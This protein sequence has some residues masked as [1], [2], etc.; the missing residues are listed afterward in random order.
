MAQPPAYNR[1]YNFTD[2][3]TL[4]PA[5]PLPGTSVDAEYNAV[6]T[7]LAAT[8]VNLA[9]LQRD[10][11]RLRN[12][13][14][15][16][17]SFSTAA[18]TMIGSDFLPRGDWVGSG[19][20]Y[21]VNNMVSTGGSTYVCLVAHVSATLFA[22][23]LAA[24][25]WQRIQGLDDGAVT[26]AKLTDDA[27]G[28]QDITTKLVGTGK[29]G[30]LSSVSADLQAIMDK[31]A[32]T[33]KAASLS[34][35]S[36]DLDAITAKL[37]HK[38]AY[39]GEVSR[40]LSSILNTGGAV[41]VR[42]FGAALDGVT[43]DTT[44]WNLALAT[45][46][47]ILFPEGDSVIT[48]RLNMPSIEGAAIVGM[49]RDQSTFLISYATFNMAT[50]AVIKMNAAYQ[51]LKN[52]GMSFVQPSTAVRASVKQYPVAISLNGNSRAELDCLRIS[53]GYSGVLAQ[54]N[55]GGAV[56]SD[57]QM[58]TLSQ[59][60][61][62]DGALD[63][64]R[65]NDIQCW[66]FGLTD[67][68]LLSVYMDGTNVAADF[69]RCDDLCI[70]GMICFSSRLRFEDH[71]GGDSFGYA[72]NVALDTEY[73]RLEFVNGH[74]SFANLDG[75][76]SVAA[77]YKIDQ[78][79]GEL[80]ITNLQVGG[81]VQTQPLVLVRGTAV[82]SASNIYATSNAGSPVFYQTGGVMKLEGGYIKDLLGT[83]RSPAIHVAGGRATVT[84]MRCSDYL[85]GT[86]NFI[87]VDSDDYHVI[88][89]NS[90]TGWGYGLPATQA[91]GIY[92]P[93]NGLSAIP[94]VNNFAVGAARTKK[95]TGTLS[96]AGAVTVAHGITAA[97]TNVI[98]VAAW[99]TAAGTEIVN[100]SGVTVD[101]TNILLA[102]GG[103]SRPYTI[104]VTYV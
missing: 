74:M 86:R 92:G 16:P 75:S 33:V 72:T 7:T 24:S 14:V 51:C 67:A 87:Q 80:R 30:F 40:L 20:L 32:G 29:A 31:L 82:F 21:S 27:A 52:F 102:G 93:N 25:R 11:G 56:I 70:V 85:G 26:A 37:R 22:T 23:D 76:T 49:G 64:V 10:D 6:R 53:A 17:E 81:N 45:G 91:S 57:I 71:G 79:G 104:Y 5:D 99:Y 2:Y 73:S 41:D 1:Q 58:G 13:T 78:S 47:V 48:G 8:L 43:D 66:P 50:D 15:T 89:G 35:V 95:I 94:F 12:A 65:M 46:K 9:L 61:V 84:G 60:F 88:T 69:G 68:S 34:S 36:A 54:G 3:Q 19:T 90:F 62:V 83:N 97:Q 96:G 39:T 44:A 103:A 100:I 77:D 98:S 18:L 38:G 101:G 28:L 59:G 4:H 63:S 42:R 55:C